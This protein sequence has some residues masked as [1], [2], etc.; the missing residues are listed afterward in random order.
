MPFRAPWRVMALSQVQQKYLLGIALVLLATVGWSL[1][2]VFVRF[3]PGL[4]G[5]QINCWRGLST[6]VFLLLYL[7]AAYGRDWQRRFSLVPPYAILAGSGFFAV[8]STLYVTSLTLT[9]TA[10]VS[11]I[12]AMSPL[13]VAAAS[14]LVLRERPHM[15]TWA[16]ALLALFGVFLIFQDGLERGNWLG[17]A[18]AILVAICFAG[19]TVTLRRFRNVD[20]VPAICLGGFIAF[21]LA[22]IFGGGLSVA[23]SDIALLTFMGPVQLAIPLILFARSARY[24]Q[25]ATLSLI[26]LLDA[27]LNP[28]WSW[29]G[30]GEIPTLG[31]VLGGAI[32]LGAVGVSIIAG[33]RTAL[34]PAGETALER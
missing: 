14:G 17:S 30:V 13:F 16:A 15:A 1:A 33:Q 24:V 26:S 25:A 3:L 11:C 31:A 18:V 12:G 2:G 7:M 4:T 6:S 28:F 29:L 22:G 8:G 23:P 32:I 21:L 9:G 20:M 19:Q 27:V 10:N 5:W 34:D